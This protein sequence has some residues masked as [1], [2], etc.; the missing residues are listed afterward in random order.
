MTTRS[1]A[2]VRTISSVSRG[3][4]ISHPTPVTIPVAARARRA[5]RH[6]EAG[7]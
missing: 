1:A 3:S 7:P 2:P 5:A 4:V 6:Q